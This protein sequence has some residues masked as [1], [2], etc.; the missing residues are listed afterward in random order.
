MSLE[1]P[2]NKTDCTSTA[3]CFPRF[4]TNSSSSFFYWG[5]YWT[6]DAVKRGDGFD[7]S[8]NLTMT[9]AGGG[10]DLL[11]N[12]PPGC[13]EGS[14]GV[15]YEKSPLIAYDQVSMDGH[16]SSEVANVIFTISNFSMRDDGDG[17][18][19]NLPGELKFNFTGVWWADGAGLVT[20]EPY[21]KPNGVKAKPPAKAHI[22]GAL[23][24]RIIG[25]TLGG[26]LFLVILVCCWCCW[27]RRRAVPQSRPV[28]RPAPV[29]PP[30]GDP[31]PP[32]ESLS[33]IVSL[34]PGYK[35]GYASPVSKYPSGYAPPVSKHN[36]GYGPPASRSPSGYASHFS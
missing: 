14:T 34:P 27:M 24:G 7:I 9:K 15:S 11:I 12:F 1:D 36:S 19:I 5:Q 2:T 16:V 35:S 32:D 29:Y 28:I 8:G 31:V 23:L 21:P 20:T 33:D 6:L 17:R 18:Q 3:F 26:V 4:E 25:G 30:Q 10:S 13:P 22:S